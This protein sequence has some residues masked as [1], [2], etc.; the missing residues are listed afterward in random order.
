LSESTR[1]YSRSSRDGLVGAITAGFFFVL[2]GMIFVTTPNLFGSIIEFFKDFGLVPI[3]NT[4]NIYF[5]APKNPNNHLTVYS[6]AGQFSLIFGIFLI[7]I[8]VLRFIIQSP[9][10]KKADTAGDIV[11]WLGA[12]YLIGMFLK[13]SVTTKIWFTFW[14]AIIML[15]GLTLIIRAIVLATK[16]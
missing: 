9:L 15:I 11:F 12:N 7:F 16:P 5:P 6:A 3:P 1:Y 4:G 8:L 13:E 14:A 10:N 2:I